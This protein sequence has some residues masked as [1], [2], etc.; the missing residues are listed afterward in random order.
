MHVKRE[1]EVRR[2]RQTGPRD[3]G[4]QYHTSAMTEYLLLHLSPKSTAGHR[5]NAA[6]HTPTSPG[7]SV[8]EMLLRLGL[9]LILSLSLALL[10]A[11]GW[12]RS[13]PA[14]TGPASLQAGPAD[15][16]PAR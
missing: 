1:T 12:D 11:W 4:V 5:Q 15:L 13:E 16:I 14:D 6:F 9:A 10:L 7:N 8:V 3:S 2:R